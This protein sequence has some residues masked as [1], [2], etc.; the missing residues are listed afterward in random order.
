MT[1]PI[2]IVDDD[3]A[4][5]QLVT[6][7]LQMGG[8]EVLA[9]SDGRQALNMVENDQRIGLVVSDVVMPG[10]TGVQLC[11][12]LRNRR[13]RLKCILMSGNDMGLVGTAKG[14]AHFLAKPFYPRDLLQKVREV[15]A[16]PAS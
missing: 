7:V 11:E 12:T 16:V 3:P 5:A 10:M 1:E 6:T 9:A 8:Y 2:L 15:L 4:I 13:P 14:V